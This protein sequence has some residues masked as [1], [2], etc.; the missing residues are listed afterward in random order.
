[1][2]KMHLVMSFPLLA[3]TETGNIEHFRGGEGLTRV[4]IE[5]LPEPP[6]LLGKK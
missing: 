4:F 3:N 5:M 1:M 6:K 2:L